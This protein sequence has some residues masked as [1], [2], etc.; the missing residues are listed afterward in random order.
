MKT[1][2]KRRVFSKTQGKF[3]LEPF[4]GYVAIEGE[5]IIEV[6]QGSE[7]SHLADDKT[8]ILNYGNQTIMT[9]F[10]DSHTHLLMAGMFKT[11]VNLLDARSEEE[12]ALMVKASLMWAS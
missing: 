3:N 2:V 7:Y 9:G 11:Y 8:K 10:H 4:K 12:A 6:G 1:L 5:K